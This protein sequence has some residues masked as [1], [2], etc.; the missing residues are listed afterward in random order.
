[1]CG[2]IEFGP[3]GKHPLVSA[4]GEQRSVQVPWKSPFTQGQLLH[5]SGNFLVSL[6]NLNKHNVVYHHKE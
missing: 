4:D 2:F 1:M 3:V 6:L 5:F